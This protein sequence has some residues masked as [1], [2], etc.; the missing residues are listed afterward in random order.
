MARGNGR[1]ESR[2]WNET[3]EMLQPGRQEEELPALPS[4]RRLPC[5]G[6]RGLP[7]EKAAAP[8]SRTRSGPETPHTQ[9][10]WLM[11]KAKVPCLPS[12]M[13]PAPSA[14]TGLCLLMTDAEQL[15]RPVA[16]CTSLLL[17]RLPFGSRI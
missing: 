11:E 17:E 5:G 16:T 4:L 2:V 1:A 12:S 9:Q 8:L 3:Q 6:P 10:A 15:E 13:R 14:V 7:A